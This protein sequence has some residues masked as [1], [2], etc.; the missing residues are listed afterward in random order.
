MLARKLPAG[1]TTAMR[2]LFGPLEIAGALIRDLPAPLALA[3]NYGLIFGDMEGDEL[4]L[5]NEPSAVLERFSIGCGG[6]HK[7][8]VDGDHRDFSES[9]LGGTQGD[10][11][12]QGERQSRVRIGTGILPGGKLATHGWEIHDFPVAHQIKKAL[13][14]RLF[15]IP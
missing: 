7:G 11:R 5:E 6:V 9:H 12:S 15:L 10:S 3:E 4:I 8:F 2:G 14:Q 1:A 13:T